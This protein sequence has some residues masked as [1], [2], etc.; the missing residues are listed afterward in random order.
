MVKLSET[1][2][3]LVVELVELRFT[4]IFITL[5][6]VFKVHNTHF[7]IIGIRLP[8]SSSDRSA[9]EILYLRSNTPVQEGAVFDLQDF[10]TADEDTVQYNVEAIEIHHGYTPRT[11]HTPSNR[12]MFYLRIVVTMSDRRSPAVNLSSCTLSA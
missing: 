10:A 4:S 5:L 1:E 3:D 2:S 6:P 7:L 8:N 12:S 11:L 9:A